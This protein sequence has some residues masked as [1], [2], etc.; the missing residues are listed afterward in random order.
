MLQGSHWRVPASPRRERGESLP[1]SDFRIR[2]DGLGPLRWNEANGLVIDAQQQPLAGAVIAF[3]DAGAGDLPRDGREA[4]IEHL[5]LVIAKMRREMFGPRSE[6]SQRLLDQMELQLEE[7]AAAHSE[8]AAR[9]DSASVEVR[10][11]TRRKATRRNFPDDLP[12]HR[13]V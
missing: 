9:S 3:A 4:M 2:R 11:F 13:F 12:R 5:Q 1:H 7:L 8:D 10:S 6:R